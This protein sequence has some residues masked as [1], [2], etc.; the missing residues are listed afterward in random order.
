MEGTAQ[1]PM[2]QLDDAE[3]EATAAG[4]SQAGSGGA[5][6]AGN[7]GSVEPLM[8]PLGSTSTATDDVMDVEAERAEE[9]QGEEVLSAEGESV[10]A[11][12]EAELSP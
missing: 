12:I 9:A 11:E 5:S 8:A 1:W 7:L 6:P 4:T 3:T 10:A 2:T